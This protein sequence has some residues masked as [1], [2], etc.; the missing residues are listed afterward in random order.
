MNTTETPLDHCWSC[1]K[2]F[3]LATDPLGRTTPKPGDVTFC[4]ACAEPAIFTA[5]MLTRIPTTVERA[6]ILANPKATKILLA[7]RELREA[8]S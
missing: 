7:L 3:E 2:R 6:E 4:I 1:G 5:D 8:R